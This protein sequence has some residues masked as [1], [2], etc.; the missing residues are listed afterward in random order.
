VNVKRETT[1]AELAD[2]FMLSKAERAPR[3]VDTYRQ[4]V[5]HHI[6]P[7]IGS[8]AVSEATTERLGRFITQVTTDNG[9]GRRRRAGRSSAA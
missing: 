8:L 4:T 3:T 9:P 7:K 1:L 5:E 6:K 2:K